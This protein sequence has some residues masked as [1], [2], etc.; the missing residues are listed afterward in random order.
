M[1]KLS[2]FLLLLPSLSFA[3]EQRWMP[4][5]CDCVIIED[6]NAGVFNFVRFEK[7]CKAYESLE[8]RD[9]YNAILAENKFKNQTYKY[10]LDNYPGAK[11]TITER[12]GSQS[13]NIKNFDFVYDKDRV[14]AIQADGLTE[15]DYQ[16]LKTN[17]G[18]K[19]VKEVKESA[20]GTETLP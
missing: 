18:I 12:D 6:Y 2:L 9:A 20:G 7:K 16:Q 8:D 10:I 19:S 13:Q 17:L 1:K 4:D 15:A 11:Q 14:L 3:K 5:T